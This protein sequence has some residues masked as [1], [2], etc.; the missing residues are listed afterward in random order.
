MCR[1]KAAMAVKAVLGESAGFKVVTVEQQPRL[2][3]D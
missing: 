2:D 1:G 3:K